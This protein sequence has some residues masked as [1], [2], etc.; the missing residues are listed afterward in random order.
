MRGYPRVEGARAAPVVLAGVRSPV[1]RRSGLRYQESVRP[2]RAGLRLLLQDHGP[3]LC[4]RL[5]RHGCSPERWEAWAAGS[6]GRSRVGHCPAQSH[7]PACK[8]QVQAGSVGGATGVAPGASPGPDHGYKWWQRVACCVITTK[9]AGARSS[10]VVEA[11]GPGRSRA[12][13]IMR[14]IVVVTTRILVF[15]LSRI[16]L[17]RTARL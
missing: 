11:V 3:A 4:S 7:H 12:R 15:K 8:R 13:T 5:Q 10:L 1:F 6:A 14:T 2:D 16:V 9:R 17:Y